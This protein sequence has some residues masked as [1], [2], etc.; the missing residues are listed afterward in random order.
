M[1]E[2]SINQKSLSNEVECINCGHLDIGIYCSNCGSRLSYRRI[3]LTNLFSSLIDYF[4]NFEERYIKTFVS[5]TKCPIGFIEQYLSGLSERYYIPFKYF[6]LNLGI[7]FIVYS[8]FKINLIAQNAFDVEAEQMIRLKSDQYFDALINNYGSFFSLMIIPIYVYMTKIF[9]NRSAYNLA[10]RATAITFLLGHLMVFQIALHLIT[11][12]YHPFYQIQKVLVIGAEFYI[13]FILSLRFF[14]A[15][16]IH[17]IW[18][19]AVI[20]CFVF[21]A[22]QSMLALTQEILLV[23]FGE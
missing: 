13:F 19:S 20:A 22:M 10:E 16:M 1:L 7:H 21:I 3:S 4:S 15:P 23:Y 8:N 11:A 17:A 5:I 6:L 12:F 18:K 2:T 14:K 9:F